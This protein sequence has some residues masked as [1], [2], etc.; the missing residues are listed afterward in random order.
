MEIDDAALVDRAVELIEISGEVHTVVLDNVRRAADACGGI[1]AVFGHFVSGTGDDEAGC[2]G[3]VE[4]V[5][6]IA[7]GTHHVDVAVTVQG[8]GHA[9]GEDAVAET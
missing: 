7:T 2:R 5:L 4:R 3:D 9:R 8:Y 6:A 1:V